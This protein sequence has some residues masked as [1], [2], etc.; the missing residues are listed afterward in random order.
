MRVLGAL[1]VLT[2]LAGLVW[3]VLD[4]TL[5]TNVV[6]AGHLFEVALTL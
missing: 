2:L 6:E 1:V 5:F 4:M 3:I